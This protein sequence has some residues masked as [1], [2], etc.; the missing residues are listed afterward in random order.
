MS[1]LFLSLSCAEYASADIEYLRK[2]NYVPPSYNIEKLCTEDPIS[3]SIKLS[4]MFHAFFI[5][6]GAL[7]KVDHYCIK[8]E[9]LSPQ[10]HRG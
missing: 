1:S 5:K 6:G 3:V 9:S 8:K 4:A 10:T 7:G 2:V